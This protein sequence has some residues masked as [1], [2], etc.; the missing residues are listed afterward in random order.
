MLAYFV[1]SLFA[2]KLQ[3]L[4]LT[5]YYLHIYLFTKSSVNR[6]AVFIVYNP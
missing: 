1:W 3:L 4:L 5:D 6:V 2:F